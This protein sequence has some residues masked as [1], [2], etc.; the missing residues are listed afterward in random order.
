PLSIPK[1]DTHTAPDNDN[2]G[3][4]SLTTA[5]CH[6]LFLLLGAVHSLC[7]EYKGKLEKNRSKL[8]KRTSIQKQSYSR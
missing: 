8:R 5:L 4:L 2:L 3:V 7:V 1:D 6:D